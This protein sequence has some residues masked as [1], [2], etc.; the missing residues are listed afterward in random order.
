MKAEKEV[1]AYTIDNALYKA[2]R[3]SLDYKYSGDRRTAYIA[4]TV[5]YALNWYISTARASVQFLKAFVNLS[6]CRM[7]TLFKKCIKAD[8]GTEADAIRE[9]KKYLKVE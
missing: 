7:N 1:S 9:I 5:N 4:I 2:Y 6:D 8:T 3:K